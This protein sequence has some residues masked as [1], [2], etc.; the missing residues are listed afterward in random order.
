MSSL[1]CGRAGVERSFL[2][3]STVLVLKKDV[4]NMTCYLE[5]YSPDWEFVRQATQECGFVTKASLNMNVELLGSTVLEYKKD[6]S[7]CFQHDI[8]GSPPA[9]EALQRRGKNS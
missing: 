4:S 7:R 8:N 2:L 9:T 5:A 6:A 3:S 1:A